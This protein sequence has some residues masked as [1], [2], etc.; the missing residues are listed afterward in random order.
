GG[1]LALDKHDYALAARK[2]EEGLKQLPDDPELQYGVARA[3]APSD[4]AATLSSLETVLERNSNHVGSLLL[5]IDHTID[6]EDYAEADKLLDRI[7]AVNPWHP[8]ALSYQA[9]LA[10]LSN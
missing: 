3:Y 7:K 5:L 9:V 6:A 1:Q 4:Q 10:H 2:F 8:E